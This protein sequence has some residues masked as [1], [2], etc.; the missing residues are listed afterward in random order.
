MAADLS[1]LS[2][3]KFIG[4]VQDSRAGENGQYLRF[5]DGIASWADITDDGAN[6]IV[7]TR[8]SQDSLID[9]AGNVVSFGLDEEYFGI[10]N[11]PLFTTDERNTGFAIFL[12]TQQQYDARIW[13][14]GDIFI[15]TGDSIT[16]SV[17]TVGTPITMDI[18]MAQ[19]FDRVFGYSVSFMEFANRD[20]LH[21]ITAVEPAGTLPRISAFEIEATPTA[22]PDTIIRRNLSTVTVSIGSGKTDGAAIAFEISEL[23]NLISADIQEPSPIID[24]DGGSTGYSIV[25]NF[26]TLANA[27]V[28]TFIGLDA[29]G[30]TIEPVVNAI[31]EFPEAPTIFPKE[32][33]VTTTYVF[34]KNTMYIRR[35]ANDGWLVYPAAEQE[36][37]VN[38]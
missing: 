10:D 19:P 1:I 22:G 37:I 31:N 20:R 25:R 29:G 8:G 36:F 3:L 11:A 28:I 35:Q 6:R 18:P 7:T 24:T 13:R 4:Y 21:F 15:P 33:A 34:I 14:P 16:D 9:N 32:P 17:T 30:D 27:N 5:L 26:V 23:L 2:N 38:T 12:S